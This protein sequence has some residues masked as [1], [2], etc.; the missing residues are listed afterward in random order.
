MATTAKKTSIYAD[1]KATQNVTDVTIASYIDALE[2]LFVIKDI[3]AWTPQIRSKT[4]IRSA[5][6]IFLLI[7]Q[8]DLQHWESVRNIFI[9]I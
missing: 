4:A 9:T 5:K 3:D 7:R 8:S 6:N 1:V 2:A